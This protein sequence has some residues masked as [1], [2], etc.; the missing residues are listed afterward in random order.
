MEKNFNN[1]V[2]VVDDE[3]TVRDSF[4]AILQ[5]DEADRKEY[6]QLE[7]ASAVLFNVEKTPVPKTMKRSSATFNFE[8]NEASNGKQAYEMVKIAVEEDRPYAAVFIDMRMPGWDGL[9]TVGHLR[10]VDKRCE[11]IF[12]TAYSDHSIEEIV[13]S[14]GTNV[15]Y[16]CK[17]F[18]VEEIEQIATKA[19]Y[20]WNKTRSLEDLIQVISKLRAQQWQM[21]PLMKNILQQVAY[22]LGTH[23]AMIA[24][25]KDN[26]YVKLFSIGNL[27]DDE[28]AH[29]YLHNIPA[30]IKE[31]VAYYNHEYAYFNL[32]K[33][34]ILAIF[35][36]GGKPLNQERTYLVQL[37]LE[38]AVQAIQNVGLQE[39]LLRQEKLSAVGEATSMIVHDL[40]NSIGAIELAIDMITDAI[41]DRDFV[42]ETLD[43]IKDSARSG[44]ALAMD[45]LDF[46]SNKKVEKFSINGA[47]LAQEVIDKITPVCE[48]HKVKLEVDCPEKIYFNAD[49]SKLYRV[50]ANLIKNAAEAFEGKK[51]DSP[52]IKMSIEN[53][54]N[55]ILMQVAD[56]GPG[57][58]EEIKDN[59]F[60][61]FVTHGKSG[62]TGLGL[63]IVKQIIEAH[64][65]TI[66]V[67]TSSTG[68]EF[69][70]SIPGN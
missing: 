22:L 20:E 69:N 7:E 41:E 10:E 11:I 34:G 53:S 38:Q 64:G 9:E 30:S 42:L 5:P 13:T 32:R 12:V 58:P 63:A 66:N 2:L 43:I 61:P 29:Y 3:E 16:H 56:N 35:E 36:K 28:V 51:I 15:S 52:C 60:M 21:E 19:V 1:R 44:T 67:K 50:L 33:Y 18:S 68:T 47:D 6:T 55:N 31:E 39:Q 49:F 27:C 25:K 45:I 54:G 14:V 24:M 59:L 37:F 4:R 23:S 40:K 17:P 8:F 57:I 46:T 26:G 70:I 62:G 65:G 48:K